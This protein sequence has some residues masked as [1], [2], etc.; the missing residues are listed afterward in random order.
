MTNWKQKIEA[1][2]AESRKDADEL[3]IKAFVSVDC[4]TMQ[5]LL[6]VID[7]DR[8]QNLMNL[9]RK[10]AEIERLNKRHDDFLQE[11][12]KTNAENER[13]RA[14]LERIESNIGFSKTFLQK[15]AREALRSE[16]KT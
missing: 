4:D 2:I 15:I 10:D 1:Q 11:F 9:K 8:V 14:A 5:A 3:G 12:W 16:Q 13:L 6:D 7:T